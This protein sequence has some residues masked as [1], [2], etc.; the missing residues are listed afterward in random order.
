MPNKQQVVH[1]PHPLSHRFA[2]SP[3]HLFP[4]PVDIFAPLNSEQEMRDYVAGK[5]FVRLPYEPEAD[6]R[7]A[8]EAFGVQ[9]LPTLIIVNGDTGR[10][11]TT[12]GRSAILKN[13]KECIREWRAGRHGVSW[14]QLLKPW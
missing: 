9:A 2:I 3:P 6:R 14:L 12:W 5:E 11:V 7:K 4:A 13:P 8:A 1:V 10:I